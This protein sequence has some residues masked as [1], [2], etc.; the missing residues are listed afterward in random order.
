[1]TQTVGQPQISPH[2]GTVK[3]SKALGYHDDGHQVT[4]RDGIRVLAHRFRLT[5]PADMRHWPPATISGVDEELLGMCGAT[6][7]AGHQALPLGG[8]P[9][10]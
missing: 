4:N 9:H 8:Y 7:P 1:V 3:V 5:A 10:A 6:D 2:G